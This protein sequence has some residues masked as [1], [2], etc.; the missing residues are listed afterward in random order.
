MKKIMGLIV[1]LFVGSAQASF[2]TA[3]NIYQVDGGS[4]VDYWGFSVTTSGMVTFDILSWEAGPIFDD[5]PIANPAND[6]NQDGEIAFLDT[7]IRLFFEEDS[8]EEDDYIAENDDA[9]DVFGF[10]YSLSFTDGSEF[11]YDSFLSLRLDVGNYI[12]A[13][14]AYDLE[15][16]EA[17]AGLNDGS[18]N[19]STCLG[20][21]GQEC[22]ELLANDHG[23]Y[24]ITWSDNVVITS[25]PG[26]AQ[27]V[28]E[29][30]ALLF[31]GLGLV[32]L[33][34]STKNKINS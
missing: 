6:L 10:G 33:G 7:H 25:D 8:L 2:I 26:T 9:E 21:I 4:S 18:L 5:S 1:W 23:D 13:I 34:L 12:L 3:G 22:V 11:H 20:G 27:R 24:Q 14:G 16:E 17:I 19:E 30:S 32:G 15:M 29:P 31:L 28:P